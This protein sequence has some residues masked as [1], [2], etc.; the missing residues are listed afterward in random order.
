MRMKKR[1]P[2]C[3]CDDHCWHMSQT[4][5]GKANV[6]GTLRSNTKKPSPFFL[7]EVIVET[8]IRNLQSSC[9]W[10]CVYKCYKMLL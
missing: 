4:W 5:P 2:S 9:S 3:H 10:F 8:D 7:F 6:F 1:I